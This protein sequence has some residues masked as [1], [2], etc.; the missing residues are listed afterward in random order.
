MRTRQGDAGTNPLLFSEL[1]VDRHFQVWE[2]GSQS[3][4][5]RFQLIDST[6]AFTGRSV[7]ILWVYYFLQYEKITLVDRFLDKD[8][9]DVFTFVVH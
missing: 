1:L 4:Y 8:A 3:E 2:S 5:E 9:Y 6:H 7:S